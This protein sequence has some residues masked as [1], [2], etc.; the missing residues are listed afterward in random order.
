MK[1]V[2]VRHGIRCVGLGVLVFLAGCFSAQ[3]GASERQGDA[4]AVTAAVEAIW[5]EYSASLNAGD[6]DRWLS[7]WTEDGVQLPPDE[8]P[9]V[10]KERIRVRNRSVLER[11]TFDMAITNEEVGAAGDWAYA[12]GIY[13]ATLTPK[14]GGVPVLIDGKYMSILRRQSDGSWKIQRDIFN[15]NVARTN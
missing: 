7:L 8:G 9:V 2:S 4:A 1:R 11:F 3:Q 5:K 13:R 12:R 10:G 6:L 15:S 14:Q